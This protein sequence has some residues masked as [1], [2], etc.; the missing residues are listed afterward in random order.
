MALSATHVIGNLEPFRPER[1]DNRPMCT[2]WMEQYF[3]TNGIQNKTKNRVIFLTLISSKLWTITR[4]A[5]ASKAGRDCVCNVDQD[6]ER[7]PKSQTSYNS[8]VV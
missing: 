1:G 7:S 6:N 3:A 5:D 2:E 4:F 8:G